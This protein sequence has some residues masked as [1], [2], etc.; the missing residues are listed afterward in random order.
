MTPAELDELRAWVRNP[1][2]GRDVG[3][4]L[5]C[6][7]RYDVGRACDC[8]KER[9]AALLVELD[10]AREQTGRLARQAITRKAYA[11]D[12]QKSL[13]R[14]K[15]RLATTSA[16]RDQMW[17]GLSAIGEYVTLAEVPPGAH[18]KIDVL[19]KVNAAFPFPRFE[20]QPR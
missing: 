15:K 2:D 8:G 5:S 19:A 16:E 7:V 10:R 9:A 11:R 1:G 20:Y 13:A 14:T 4:D 12:L 17:A 6:C 3:R 18:W